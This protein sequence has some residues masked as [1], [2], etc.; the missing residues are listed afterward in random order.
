M[1]ILDESKNENKR[2][3]IVIEEIASIIYYQDTLKQ[4]DRWLNDRIAEGDYIPE[5]MC[6]ICHRELAEG[7]SCITCGENF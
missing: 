2:L 7:G 1:G 6:P 3:K 5:G 4:Q